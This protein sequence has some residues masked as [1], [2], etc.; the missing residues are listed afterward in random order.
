MHNEISS[1]INE[2]K[3]G[4]INIMA[5]IENLENISNGEKYKGIIN[6]DM[7][8]VEVVNCI[9]QLEL[10]RKE[11]RMDKQDKTIKMLIGVILS[12]ILIVVGSIVWLFSNYDFYAYNQ[13]IETGNA[14]FIGG[15]GDITN[16]ETN[17]C[18]GET[19]E[20]QN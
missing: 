13:D 16:G 19:E 4:A 7:S 1:Q 5:Q 2:L 14:N 3:K 10:E 12:I 18:L 9:T 20:R 8:T 6:E 11:A 15:N 17:N